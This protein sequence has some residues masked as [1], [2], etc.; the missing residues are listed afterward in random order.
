MLMSGTKLPTKRLHKSSS[1]AATPTIAEQFVDVGGAS[2]ATFT[3]G[4]GSGRAKDHAIEGPAASTVA[5]F[6]TAGSLWARGVGVERWACVAA[7]CNCCVD[8]F[9]SVSVN[10]AVFFGSLRTGP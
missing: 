5:E 9:W 8:W 1:S 10:L 3:S 6:R 7:A 4:N 2:T